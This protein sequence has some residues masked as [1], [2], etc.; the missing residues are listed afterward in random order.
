[1][2]V[3]VI[4][5]QIKIIPDSTELSVELEFHTLLVCT[6]I[7]ELREANSNEIVFREKG[8]N[9]NDQDD[10]H[11]IGT[12]KENDGRSLWIILTII[13]QDGKGGSYEVNAVVKQNKLPI[14]DGTL[15]T[16]KKEIK[17][18]ENKH[19]FVLVARLKN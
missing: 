18:K 8:D 13:N 2:P 17:P 12:G 16:G 10:E 5:K 11:K 6:Y 7:V 19:D 15:T 1:M 3:A 9:T 4:K 14:E